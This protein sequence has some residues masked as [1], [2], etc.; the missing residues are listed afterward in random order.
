MFVG[1]P[2]CDKLQELGMKKILA[3]AVA[4]LMSASALAAACVQ[5]QSNGSGQNAVNY[6]NYDVI[7]AWRSSDGGC[8][9]GALCGGSIAA[10][11]W[12][13]TSNPYY[14]GVT[15]WECPYQSWANNT[16]SLPQ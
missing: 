10:G 5:F 16:C 11:S 4:F 3:S 12:I 2:A 6:C 8:S 15:W 7:I 9:T 1:N 13:A 14:A